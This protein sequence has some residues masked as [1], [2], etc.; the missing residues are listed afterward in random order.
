MGLFDYL[1]HRNRATEQDDEIRD[2]YRGDS[3]NTLGGNDVITLSYGNDEVDGGNGHDTVIIR[4]AID[5]WNISYPVAP[6][7]ASPDDGGTVPP[8]QADTLILEHSRYGR[9]TLTNIENLVDEQGDSFAIAPLYPNHI[10]GTSEADLLLDTVSDDRISAGNGDDLAFLTYGNDYVSGNSGVD[11]VHIL[12]E[13]DE[14]EMSTR[15][16]GESFYVYLNSD[17]YGDKTLFNVEEVVTSGGEYIDV[18][19]L[20]DNGDVI[21]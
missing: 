18:I 13:L 11:K 15:D 17:R 5:E 8:Y 4:G 21:A 12:G 3:I 6:P 2:S 7:S 14:Y 19:S 9:K 20:L 16:L 10:V 1:W